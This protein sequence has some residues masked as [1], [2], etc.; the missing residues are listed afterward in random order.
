MESAFP[1][2]I[3]TRY[4]FY[5]LGSVPVRIAFNQ[6]DDPFMAEI[7]SSENGRLIVD[8]S[9]IPDILIG[10]PD[11]LEEITE[12]EFEEILKTFQG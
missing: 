8:N 12:A 2:N 7:P 3:L 5:R 6:N 4:A 9:Y 10:A 1:E 11:D